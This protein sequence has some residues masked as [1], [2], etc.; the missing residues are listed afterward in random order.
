MDMSKKKTF[1]IGE[2]VHKSGV[3]IRT[4][5]YYD[6]IDLL[7][8]SDYT[9]GGHRLY[10]E[11]DFQQLQQIKSLK[12]IGFSLKEIKEMIQKNLVD[13]YAM[14]QSLEFQKQL[15]IAKN[16][17]INEILSDLTHLIGIVEGKNTININTF[18]S[19]LHKLM[20]E[21][22][23]KAWFKKHFSKTLTEDIFNID[24]DEDLKLDKEWSDILS[25][26]KLLANSH[27]LP[28]SEKAQKK[29]EHLLNLMNQTLKGNLD[30]VMTELPGSD[31][32]HFPNPFTVKEQQFL[33]EAMFIYE[34]SKPQ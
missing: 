28:S 17:E 24:K 23:T 2:F 11:D 22:D 26:I 25:D 8:P 30:T 20:F 32:F 3:N 13:G 16:Q 31:P 33:K 5:R 18:S 4:L 34:N 29:V 10:S 7:K 14:Q 19:M 15:F 12:F 21:E 9:E 27:F 6:S 1:T